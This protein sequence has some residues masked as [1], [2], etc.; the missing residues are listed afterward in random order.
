MIVCQTII[1]L[2]N[3]NNFR[4]QND[5]FAGSL[6]HLVLHKCKLYFLHQENEYSY[7]VCVYTK[8]IQ[9]VLQVFIQLNKTQVE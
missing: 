9:I 1:V 5:L 2:N 7:C 8:C 3:V 6:R 4:T